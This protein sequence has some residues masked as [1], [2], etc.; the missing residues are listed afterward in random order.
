MK[1]SNDESFEKAMPKRTTHSQKK[2]Y[3]EQSIKP[4]FN[5]KKV[6]EQARL[7]I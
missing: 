7:D 4:K 6:G 5:K 3:D 2:N 1:K